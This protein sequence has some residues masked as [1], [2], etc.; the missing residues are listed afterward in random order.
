MTH[1]PAKST[2][3]RV[4][5]STSAQLFARVLHLGFNLVSTLAIVRYLAPDLYGAY[6]LVMTVTALVGLVT[7]FGLGSLA[8]REITGAQA[9]ENQMLGTIVVLRLVLGVLSMA[10]AQAVLSLMH[11]SPLVHLAA[12]VASTVCLADAAL[13]TI[14][15]MFQVRLVQHYEAFIRIIMEAIE[16]AVVLVLVAHRASLPLLVAPPLLGSIIGAGLAFGLARRRYGLQPVFAK[17]LIRRLIV[18][19]LPIGPALFLGVVYLKLDNLVLAAMR[20]RRDVGLYGSAYQPIEYLFLASAVVIGV[21][22]P[23][24]ATAHGVGDQERFVMLYRRGTELLVMAALGVPVVMLF[25]AGP[26]VMVVFGKPYAQA[27]GPLQLLSVVLVLMVVNAWQSIVLLA[28]GLQA[29]TLRYNA[30]ALGLSLCLCIS[31]IGAFGLLGAPLAAL[32]T[33]VFVLCA[34]TS[35]VRRHLG[36]TLDLGRLARI[37]LAGVVTVGVLAMLRAIGVPWPFVGLLA[38]VPYGACL[39]G[40]RLHRQ[41]LQVLA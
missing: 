30:M 5:V 37:G 35:A 14:V 16:T 17:A 27:A 12:A 28:G 26:L 34:S 40:L 7:D 8:V 31:C 11:Q 41:F 1:R 24:L 29:M 25:V 2:G 15:V 22:F 38:V 18:L 32:G 21:I 9:N 10:T 33:A 4:V 3:H 23:L 13:A 36:A 19:A 6:V 20:P 39:L